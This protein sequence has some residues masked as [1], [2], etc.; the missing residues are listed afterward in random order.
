[1][2]NFDRV[3][4]F[5]GASVVAI[6]CASPAMAQTRTYSIPAQSAAGGVAALARQ[7]DQQVLISARDAKGKKTG[8][9]RGEMTIEQAFAKLLAGSGLTAKRTGAGAWAVVQGGN[10]QSGATDAAGKAEVSGTVTDSA[11]G[12]RLVGALVRLAPSG[13]TAVT[14]E[15]GQYRIVGVP[16]GDLAVTVSFLGL[17]TQQQDVSVGGGEGIDVDFSM[18]VGEDIIVYG[19]KSARA[20]ALNRERTAPNST[21]VISSDLLG[22]F[23]GTTISEALRRAP[24]VAFQKDTSTGD[25]TNII[26]RGLAPEYNQVRLNGIAIPDSAAGGRTANLGNILADSVSEIKISKTLLPSQDSAGTGGLV[27]IETKSPLDRPRRFASFGIEGTKRAKGYGE[28]FL[29]SGTLSARFGADS[30]F[31]LSGSIQYR[32]QDVSTYSY[33]VVGSNLGPYLPK[34]RFGNPSQLFEIDPRTP[35]PFEAGAKG[36]Y[37]S[38]LQLN[39]SR[40]KVETIGTNLAAEWQLSD[41]TN[42]KLDYVRADRRSDAFSESLTIQGQSELSLLPVQSLNGE[43]RFVYR[44]PLSYVSGSLSARVSENERQTTNA[45]SFRGQTKGRNWTA[46]YR[47]GFS[48]GQATIPLVSAIQ[49]L[50]PGLSFEDAGLLLPSVVDPATGFV[51]TIFGPRDGTAIPLPLFT[52]AGFSRI[53]SPDFTSFNSVFQQSGLRRYNKTINGALDFRYD[54]NGNIL[55]Y[56][57]IGFDY[58]QSKFNSRNQEGVNYTG[59][60]NSSFM[61]P[62]AASVGVEFE[63]ID[64][65]RMSNSNGS[66]R[67]A[68]PASLANLIS[69]LDELVAQ[70]RVTTRVGAKDPLNG[71]PFTKENTLVGYLEGGVSI[72]RLEVIGGARLSRIR[73]DAGV[74]N[75]VNFFNAN[76]Q[77]DPAV[78]ERYRAIVRKEATQFDFLPRILLNYRP[79]D[80][81]VIRAGY[82]STVARPE[83]A[84]LSTG[85]TISLILA[86]FFG[87]GGDQPTLEVSQ[88]NADLK[89]AVTHNFDIGAE[90]YDENVGVLK[91]NI[92]YKRINNLLETNSTQLTNLDGVTLPDD[93]RFQNL[94]GNIFLVSRKPLNNP[95]VATIWGIELA[96]ERRLDFLPGWLSG[97]GV[98]GNFTYT[99]SSK[100]QPLTWFSKPIYDASGSIVDYEQE[101]FYIKNVSFDQSPPYS[102]TV[103]LTYNKFGVDASLAYSLQARRKLIFN[104]FAMHSYDEAVDTLDFRAE[105]R[106]EAAGANF[107]LY[108]EGADLLKGRKDADVDRSVGGTRGVPKFYTE[109]YFRGGRSFTAG[110]AASF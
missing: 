66:L 6:A 43:E 84:L 13:Q 68:T 81:A 76:F 21:T 65:A 53:N 109:G 36:F 74:A 98:Y 16:S 62:S 55:K 12:R 15:Q 44:D 8:E 20:L 106:F 49:F 69:S 7:S 108:L 97:L 11:T 18:G 90:Y 10:A 57:Q 29:A 3:V 14:D 4:G 105:Y 25:G 67:F 100:N 45:L 87:P 91:A 38:G 83:P 40:N 27:E 64:F 46:N 23:Q 101:D 5:M 85:Q 103:S 93:P 60:R 22:N 89:P 79:S 50:T 73:V 71:L 35:Y 75:T 92:F 63:D 78:T 99:K 42:L 2:T 104:D 72:G 107:R 61:F 54:F 31:G 59:V 26:V 37:P 24:G 39:S 9:V 70:G 102:G 28:D 88:G 33:A 110:I 77:R 34:D 82:Y 47:A 95:D 56:L 86:P 41:S 80:K 52:E 96:A 30:N 1:M 58:T 32:K 19:T 51:T 17:T 48:D 94:P